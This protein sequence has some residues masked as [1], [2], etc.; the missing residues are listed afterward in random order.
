MVCSDH[1]IEW[2]MI[3]VAESSHYFASKETVEGH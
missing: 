2:D 1:V 3:R